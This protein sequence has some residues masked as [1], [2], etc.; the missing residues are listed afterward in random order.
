MELTI[1]YKWTA[2][3]LTTYANGDLRFVLPNDTELQ[4]HII[5]ELMVWVSYEDFI[6]AIG[7]EVFEKMIEFYNMK[8]G[9]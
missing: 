7:V 4:Q 9:E 2:M 5:S 6:E 8:F 1:P 3:D